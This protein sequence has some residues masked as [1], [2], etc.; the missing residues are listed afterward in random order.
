MVTLSGQVNEPSH[1]DLAQE[2]VT[3][4]PGVQKIDNRLKVVFEGTDKSDAWI[5]AKVR[6]VLALHRQ[7]SGSHT[8]VDVKD[9]VITLRG[10]ATS[11]A[12]RDLASEYAQD[13]NGVLRV[14]NVMVVAREAAVAAKTEAPA[15]VVIDDASITAL[16]KVALRSHHSTSA[17]TTK[18]ATAEGVVTVTGTARNEAEKA[19]VTKLAADIVGVKS[20]VNNMTL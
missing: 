16:V 8:E 7:V 11:E 1:W 19:L 14:T 5:R 9:G 17:V 10:T 2:T 20:V 4:L 15:P 18:V 13:V 12:Q 6:S 3:Q